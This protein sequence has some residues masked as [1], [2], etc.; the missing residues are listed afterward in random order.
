MASQETIPGAAASE[1]DVAKYGRPYKPTSAIEDIIEKEM[2]RLKIAVDKKIIA[3]ELE[4]EQLAIT[5]RA[6]GKKK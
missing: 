6:G 2:A 4:L 3:Q 1:Y 5:A